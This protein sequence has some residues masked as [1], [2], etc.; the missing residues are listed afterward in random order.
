MAWMV[1]PGA[2]GR[3]DIVGLDDSSNPVSNSAPDVHVFSE[4]CNLSQGE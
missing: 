3:S 1:S 4:R 2:L